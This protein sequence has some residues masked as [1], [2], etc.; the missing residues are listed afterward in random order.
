M[1]PADRAGERAQSI[2]RFHGHGRAGSNSGDL[3]RQAWGSVQI[4]ETPGRRRRTIEVRGRLVGGRVMSTV[5]EEVVREQRNV[6]GDETSA[7]QVLRDTGTEL[8]T[9][10]DCFRSVAIRPDC[11]GSHQHAEVARVRYRGHLDD[12]AVAVR[13]D[14]DATQHCGRSE[15]ERPTRGQASV[16]R[17][18]T[19][20]AAGRSTSRTARRAASRTTGRAT[21]GAAS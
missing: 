9:P 10:H 15:V 11:C 12:H 17:R 19:P 18:R 7:G 6:V 16:R 21:C 5:N 20:S 8:G 4:E 13:H 3:D 1:S 2:Q 14:R